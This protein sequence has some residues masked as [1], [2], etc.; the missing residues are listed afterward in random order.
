MNASPFVLTVMSLSSRVALHKADYQRCIL[1]FQTHGGAGADAAQ[2]DPYRI[3]LAQCSEQAVPLIS[4]TKRR[5]AAAIKAY[6]ACLHRNLPSGGAGG[7]DQEAGERLE[8]ECAGSLR[9][10]WKCTEMVK[11]ELRREAAA[12]GNSSAPDLG[13]RSTADV[14]RQAEHVLGKHF[15]GSDTTAAPAR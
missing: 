9:D 10:L 1:S 6:N 5:C 14:Q 12:P 4:A 8:R 2:C 13:G 11:A 3:A 7:D 15:A